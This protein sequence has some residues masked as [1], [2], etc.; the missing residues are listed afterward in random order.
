MLNLKYIHISILKVNQITGFNLGPKH[1]K[2]G[3]NCE[4]YKCLLKSSKDIVAFV[5]YVFYLNPS[6]ILGVRFK[7]WQSLHIEKFKIV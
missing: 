3:Q 7:S 1:I 2:T 5:G 6:S 4:A